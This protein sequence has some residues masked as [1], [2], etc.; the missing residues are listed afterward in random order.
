MGQLLKVQKKWRKYGLI[1]IPSEGKTL[2]FP[3][4]DESRETLGRIFNLDKK[5]LDRYT[6]KPDTKNFGSSWR[7]AE[8]KKA[9]EEKLF[10]KY[11]RRYKLYDEMSEP[12]RQ[13]EQYRAPFAE[14][15]SDRIQEQRMMRKQLN[16]FKDWAKKKKYKK[17]STIT[18]FDGEQGSGV[19][20]F[21][22][23]PGGPALDWKTTVGDYIKD[24]EA[25]IQARDKYIEDA[26]TAQARKGAYWLGKSKWFKEK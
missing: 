4:T 22:I 21:T 19:R 15:P 11:G 25:Q 23:S 24:Q 16:D 20:G 13:L 14:N 6:H 8:A 5:E 7:V 3:N 12:E 26:Y 9:H 2:L 17:S 18:E 1:A 10:D